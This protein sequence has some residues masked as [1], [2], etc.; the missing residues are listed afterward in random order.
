MP[1][2]WCPPRVMPVSVENELG[3]F[4]QKVEA[5]GKTVTVERRLELRQHWVKPALFPKL[6][7]LILAEH[8]AHA[9]SFRFDCESA[10][11]L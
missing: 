9:R 8:R 5:V 1:E 6:R 11:L 3:L 7:E 10:P 2:G 4:R